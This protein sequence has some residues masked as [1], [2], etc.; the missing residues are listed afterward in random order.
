MSSRRLG[1]VARSTSLRVPSVPAVSQTLILPAVSLSNPS[2]G[3]RSRPQRTFGRYPQ[4]TQIHA[5]VPQI[6]AHRRNL[7][8]NPASVVWYLRTSA[9][10]AVKRIGIEPIGIEPQMSQRTQMSRGKT[11]S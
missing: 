4:M 3:L 2:R 11:P 7:R 10:S 6:C 1:R 9:S 5:E 8:M